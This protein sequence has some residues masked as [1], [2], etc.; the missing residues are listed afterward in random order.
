MRG[1]GLMSASD[2]YGVAY[3]DRGAFASFLDV[4]PERV[5]AIADITFNS[6]SE[7]LREEIDRQKDIQYPIGGVV[8]PPEE[9][10]QQ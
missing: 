9:T 6:L 2:V 7:E 10:P 3:A 4:P 8:P 1:F 5:K